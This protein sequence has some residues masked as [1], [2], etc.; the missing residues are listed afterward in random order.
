MERQT[1]R[2]R[3]Q[4]WDMDYNK[5]AKEFTELAQEFC[6]WAYASPNNEDE[7]VFYALKILSKLYC[8]AVQLPECAPTDLLYS[9]EIPKIDYKETH[10]LFKKMPFQYYKKFFYPLNIETEEPIM[11]DL[12]DDLADIYKDLKDGLWYIERGSEAD[13]VFH[14][15]NTFGFHWGQHLVDALKALHSHAVK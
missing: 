14:W 9:E 3:R 5:Q 12:Y 10:T 2:A 7:E 1:A 4:S 11:G 15:K 13:A 6:A 8:W